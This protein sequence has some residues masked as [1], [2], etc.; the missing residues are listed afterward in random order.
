MLGRIRCDGPPVWRK[1][2]QWTNIQSAPV[3]GA[4][5]RTTWGC[6]EPF[7]WK[8]AYCG[9][10]QTV[11]DY[12]YDRTSLVIWNVGSRRGQLGGTVETIVCSNQECQEI[13]LTFHL[14]QRNSAGDLYKSPI[15]SWPLLP[16]STAKPQPDYIPKPIVDNYNQACRINDLSP[17]ASAAM[18]RRCLQGMIRDYWKVQGKPNLWAE[19]QAIKDKMDPKTWEAIDAIRKVGKIG[20]H[21]EEDVNLILDVEP[22]EA[23]AL[24]GLIEILFDDWYVDRHE[25]EQ[26][27]AGVVALGKAKQA[28]MDTTK[29]VAKEAK[30]TCEVDAAQTDPAPRS[31]TGEGSEE[32]G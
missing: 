8:C 9:H 32:D 26:R 30:E 22:A 7:N 27:V 5:S 20:A 23:Q 19:I 16:E 28:Q 13:T 24:I 1:T 18:S 4:R 15:R 25:R 31:D 6:M 2:R 29:N 11:T 10:A 17:N 14:H 12:T 21:M 3:G